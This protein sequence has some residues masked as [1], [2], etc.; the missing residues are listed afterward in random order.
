MKDIPGYEGLYAAS[1]DGQIWSHRNKI[2]MK[3][4]LT[5]M[6]YP[7]VQLC[8]NGKRKALSVHRLIAFAYL[9]KSELVVNHKNGIKRD[10]RIENLEYCTRSENIKHAFRTGL[11]KPTV[12]QGEQHG[13]SKLSNEDI[14]AIRDLFAQPNPPQ[15]RAV[16]KACGVADTTIR[17][18]IQRKRWNHVK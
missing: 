17:H 3:Q 8:V 14:L 5:S 7:T 4:Q 11:K 16:A 18:I 12:L 9:G 2:I 1:E 15:Q 6:G 13:G 10:N